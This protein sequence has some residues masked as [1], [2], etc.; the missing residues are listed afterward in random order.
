MEKEKRAEYARLIVRTG[1]NVQKGQMVQLTAAVEQHEFAALVIEECYRAGAKKVNVE[2][3]SDV[4]QRLNMMYAERETLATV[5][6][7]E[8][9]KMKQ[10]VEELPCLIYIESE[11]PDAMAGVD[12]EKLSAVMQARAKVWKPYRNAIE[13][14]HQWVIAAYPSEKWARKCFP[15][16][17][18]AADRLWDAILKTV[19]VQEGKDPVE[20]WR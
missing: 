18:D 19:H 13:G 8:E 17:E 3:T 2:W 1:A 11:D 14:K 4:Q 15:E 9:A 7:W 6:P 16:A 10:V 20:A 5:L 12:P